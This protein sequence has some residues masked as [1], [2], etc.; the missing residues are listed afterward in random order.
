MNRI[1]SV[2][3]PSAEL[4]KL[5]KPM[6][7]ALAL[8]EEWVHLLVEATTVG[9]FSAGQI[10]QIE[11][12]NAEAMYVMLRGRVKIFRMSKGGREQVIHVAGPGD[13]INLVPIIDGGPCPASLEALSDVELLVCSAPAF[14]ALLDR[15]PRL[16]MIM[17]K[18][19][20]RR[21]RRLVR[22]VDEL[23]LHTV[24]GRLIRLILDRAESAERG[25]AVVPL[26]QTEMASQIGTVREMV[27]RTL[28]T[29]EGLGL[30][31]LESG[32]ITVLDRA[33]LES[34]GES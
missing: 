18:D 30:I 1:E 10:I 25:D 22:L 26:T 12:D 29:L 9:R 21:Q 24:Q 17:M 11:G 2:P 5:M 8:P 3:M 6:A 33:G 34:R 15:E 13:H 19:L 7:S 14:Q 23:A 28:K 31:G 20:A 4:L 27:A 32:K 16:A